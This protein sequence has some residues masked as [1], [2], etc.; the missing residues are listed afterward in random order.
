MLTPVFVVLSLAALGQ[1]DP[2]GLPDVSSTVTGL[3]VTILNLANLQCVTASLPISSASSTTDLVN[4]LL[5]VAQITGVVTNTVPQVGTLLNQALALAA[6]SSAATDCPS[7]VNLV[8]S[9][10]PTQLADTSSVTSAI[11]QNLGAINIP[12]LCKEL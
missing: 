7:V 3:K 8:K 11:G 10:A 4:S 9:L 1:S 5:S 12:G 6:P 2:A